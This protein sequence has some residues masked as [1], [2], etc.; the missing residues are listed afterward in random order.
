MNRFEEALS[1]Y[2]ESERLD[3]SNEAVKKS[4]KEC[5]DELSGITILYLMTLN[6][7]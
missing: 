4:I 6:S 2:L 7:N 1:A 5:K 3:P